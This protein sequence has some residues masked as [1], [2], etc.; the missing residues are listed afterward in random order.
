MEKKG[1]YRNAI[2]RN[3]FSDLYHLILSSSWLKFFF[4]NTTLYLGINVVF[5]FFYYVGGSNIINADPGSFWDA[6]AFGF[7][8]SSTIGYGHLFP[9]NTYTDILV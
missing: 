5:A 6:F 4:I 1:L 3:Y 7:Q 8:T 2:H 9:A